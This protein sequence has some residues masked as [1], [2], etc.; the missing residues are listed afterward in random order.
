MQVKGSGIV[1]IIDD[2]PDIVDVAAI[3][4]TKEG[5]TVHSFSNPS[6]A[7]EDI[8]ECNKKMSIVITDIRMPGHTGFEIARK[9][10]AVHPDV[11]IVFMTSFEILPSE[12]EKVF[13]SLKGVD[14]LQ[15]PFHLSTLIETV[16][17]YAD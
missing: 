10:R 6:K 1:H 9:A 7:L 8:D 11:P 13:R 4:L 17:K 15:K 5:Y 3:G 2:E 16:R 14:F 12:F